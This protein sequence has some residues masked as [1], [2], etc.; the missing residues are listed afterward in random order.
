MA[1]DY[2]DRP[3]NHAFAGDGQALSRRISCANA[4]ATPPVRLK[5]AA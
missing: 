3:N 1:P 4:S 5:V 2:H